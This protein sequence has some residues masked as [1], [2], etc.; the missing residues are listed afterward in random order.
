MNSPARI[1]DA[2]NAENQQYKN[3]GVKKHLQL[4]P[5]PNEITNDSGSVRN[6]GFNGPRSHRNNSQNYD[7]NYNSANPSPLKK[8]FHN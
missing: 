5:Y 8:E 6:Y 1:R 3:A 4:N 2:A 7:F